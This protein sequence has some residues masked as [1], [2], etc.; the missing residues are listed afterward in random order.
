MN[1]EREI[2]GC[3]AHTTFQVE[4]TVCEK[5]R[6]EKEESVFGHFHATVC[7]DTGCAGRGEQRR[8]EQDPFRSPFYCRSQPD[9]AVRNKRKIGQYG[10]G[11]K[12]FIDP[13]SEP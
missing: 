11:R 4:A 8:D 9:G 1:L 3:Q 13:P 12:H 6:G 10:A 5:A 2:G 7:C